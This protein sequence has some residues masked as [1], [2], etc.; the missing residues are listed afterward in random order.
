MESVTVIHQDNGP[1]INVKVEKNTRGFNY[2]ASIT[3]APDIKTA[4]ALLHDAQV[5]LE[6]RY[7]NASA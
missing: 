2:E 5:E 4:M 7:G 3:N 1:R 6:K